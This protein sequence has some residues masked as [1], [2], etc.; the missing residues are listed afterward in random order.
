M[1]IEN[2]AKLIFDA[3]LSL[4]V[5]VLLVAILR[6]PYKLK[7]VP[8][9]VCVPTL[10]VTMAIVVKDVLS[11]KLSAKYINKEVLAKDENRTQYDED[12]WLEVM[13]MMAW[14]VLAT[15]L[16]FLFGFTVFTFVFPFCF[17]V[18]VGRLRWKQSLILTI[19]VGGITF[20]TF[21]YVLKVPLWPGYIPEI[22][23]NILG[24]GVQPPFFTK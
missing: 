11:S 3:M 13:K 1:K 8:L 19:L 10:V 14:I 23:P 24:G 16:I 7:L 12:I 6:Y 22:V 4:F 5:L 17:L 15:A 20:A 9:I 2:V 18:V 21:C